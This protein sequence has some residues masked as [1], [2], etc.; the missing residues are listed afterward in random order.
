MDAKLLVVSDFLVLAPHRSTGV[1][2]DP[3][4]RLPPPVVAQW[5]ELFA[6]NWKL[7]L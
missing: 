7:R 5:H 3:F 6:G 1:R 4:P 2:G